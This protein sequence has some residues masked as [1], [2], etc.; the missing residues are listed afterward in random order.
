M[1]SH[2]ETD[3]RVRLLSP[4]TARFLL[5]GES[6]CPEDRS[7][8]FR[9]RIPAGSTPIIVRGVTFE[10]ESRADN[11]GIAGVNSLPNA[12][13]E[14]GHRRRGREI[15]LGREQ[16]A[17]ESNDAKSGEIMAIDVFGAQR[18]RRVLDSL[19]AGADLPAS[20]LKSGDFFK[21]R[22]FG[23]Q[24][25]EEGIGEHA[26][27]VLGSAFDAAIVAVADAIEAGRV[28]DRQGA[29]HNGMNKREDGGSAA[30]A[31]SQGENGG[32]S[33]NRCEP[34]LPQSVADIAKQVAQ[35]V[36]SPSIREW[37]SRGSLEIWPPA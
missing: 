27:L 28:G 17:A 37:L 26:P 11:G 14:D 5:E 35:D 10:K 18:P 8:T 30:N 24:P 12:M 1:R 3:W 23:L 21:L 6:R 22:S 20:G 29:E 33:K 19:A 36:L 13:A 31:E 15:I 9:Q 32:N 16:A 7:P 4:L 34:E 2:A 25:Q